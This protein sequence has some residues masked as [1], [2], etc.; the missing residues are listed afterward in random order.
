M[1][2]ST[3]PP[4]VARLCDS[5]ES[6]NMN[7]SFEANEELNKCMD[8]LEGNKQCNRICNALQLLYSIVLLASS[9]SMHLL[10]TS[11]VLNDN[12]IPVLN[13]MRIAC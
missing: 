10:S 12:R 7:F 13:D 3:N 5:P 9:F 2:F 6:L 4:C 8:N 1:R 11:F